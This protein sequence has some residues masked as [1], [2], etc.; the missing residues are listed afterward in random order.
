MNSRYGS[1]TFDNATSRPEDHP[2]LLAEFSDAAEY[3]NAV[4]KVAFEAQN[5]NAIALLRGWPMVNTTV[6]KELVNEA[7][8]RSQ[9]ALDRLHRACG[10][11]GDNRGA[12][13]MPRHA[14]PPSTD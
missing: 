7:R 2:E 14:S 6:R 9:A 13:A 5:A 1:H 12:K 11:D 10:I 3:F 8:D 4:T